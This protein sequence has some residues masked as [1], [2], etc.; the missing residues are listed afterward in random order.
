MPDAIVRIRAG[1]KRP[2]FGQATAPT[3]STLIIA[4][5][6]APTC[7]LYDGAG[8]LVSAGWTNAAVTGYDS[9]AVLAPRAWVNFNTLLDP[10]GGTQVLA[11]GLY[12]LVFKFTATA[13]GGDTLTRIYEVAL[14][15]RVIGANA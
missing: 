5:S 6:P 4:A 7:N 10:A 8:V 13:A 15:I 1:E 2:I 9:T 14:V 11:A 3:G 12:T